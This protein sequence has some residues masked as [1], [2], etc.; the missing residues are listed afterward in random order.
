[1]YS[2]QKYFNH[3]SDVGKILKSINH[4]TSIVYQQTPECAL[5]FPPNAVKIAFKNCDFE[6]D[7]SILPSTIDSLILER[8]GFR[9]FHAENFP[10][11]KVLSIEE[12]PNGRP[13]LLNFNRTL[14]ENIRVFGENISVSLSVLESPELKTVQLYCN[15]FSPERT[16]IAS[17]SLEKVDITSVVQKDIIWSSCRKL[18]Y[19]RLSFNDSSMVKHIRSLVDNQDSIEGE[20]K[21]FGEKK[22]WVWNY[23]FKK[24]PEDEKARW[25]KKIP[26][27]RAIMW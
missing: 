23:I 8:T 27:T 21:L 16:P 19:L 2:L 22:P 1:M 18:N 26:H 5:I 20:I 15:I 6:V 12:R 10:N 17:S 25:K 13:A 7:C 14:L 4:I 3:G 9:N 24:I 11:L